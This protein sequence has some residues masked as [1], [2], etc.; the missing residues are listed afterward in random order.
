[1]RIVGRDTASETVAAL[2]MDGKRVTGLL[3]RE[4]GTRKV[5]M[6]DIDWKKSE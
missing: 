1:M 5:E 2:V 4:T 3:Q 6:L